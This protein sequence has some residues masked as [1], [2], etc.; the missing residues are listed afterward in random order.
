MQAAHGVGAATMDEDWQM[1]V[2]GSRGL[3]LGLAWSGDLR[4]AGHLRLRLG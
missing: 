1:F 3:A 4:A 2:R